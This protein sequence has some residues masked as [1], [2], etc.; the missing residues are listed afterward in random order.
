MRLT[1][2]QSRFFTARPKYPKGARGVRRYFWRTLII[3]AVVVAVLAL[4]A[5]L[6]RRYGVGRET[7]AEA[8]PGE[9][10]PK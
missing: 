4:G 8:P 6:A 7:P 5:W 3:A 2:R 9:R 10:S 1:R